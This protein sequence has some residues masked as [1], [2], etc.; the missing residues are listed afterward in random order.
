MGH[1]SFVDD[2]GDSLM[3]YSLP[4][5]WWRKVRTNNYMEWLIRT[6]LDPMGVLYDVPAVE[7]A[8]FGQLARWR[9]LGTYTQ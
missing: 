8:V 9:L 7:R 6:R 5:D 3:F 4:R 1:A 2:I